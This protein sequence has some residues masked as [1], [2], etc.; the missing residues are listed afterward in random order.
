MHFD[1]QNVLTYGLPLLIGTIGWIA[2]H[3]I[4]KPYLEYRALRSEIA[5][6]LILCANIPCPPQ[7]VYESDART[8]E[9][10]S[11]YR[12]L[13][14]RLMSI[15]NLMAFYRVWSIFGFIMPKWEE[16]ETAKGNLIGLSNSIGEPNQSLEISRREDNIRRLLRIK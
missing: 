5:H 13:A 10:R 4:G 8:V 6:Y 14:S 16:L 1:I 2:A 3:L 15:A 12:N 9:A 11:K 7:P